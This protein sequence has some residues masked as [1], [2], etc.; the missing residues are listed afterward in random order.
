MMTGISGSSSTIA[1]W[2]F[3][4]NLGVVFG[5][6]VYEHRIVLSRWI[7]SSSDRVAHWNADAARQDDTG[8]RFWAFVSTMPLTLLTLANLFFAWRAAGAVRGWW[9]AAAFAA[10]ADR[11]FTFSY[12]IPTMVALMR[13]PDSPESAA[14][15]TRW[16]NLN[17]LRHAIVFAAWLAAL[18]A[19]ALFHQQHR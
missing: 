8:L 12:F 16:A 15:A 10:L 11:L 1:L 18:K 2:L 9:L 17:Y 5:A 19:F 14:T 3:V 7:T 13:A 4:I 6:G